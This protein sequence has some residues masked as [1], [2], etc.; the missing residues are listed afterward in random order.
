MTSAMKTEQCWPSATPSGA[1]S[2]SAPSWA[3]DSTP[4]KRVPLLLDEGAGAGGAGLVHGGVDD[5]PAVEPDVL[6]VLPA[7]LEDGVDARVDVARAGGVG[8]DL[9][10][11]RGPPRRR[12]RWPAASR[13]SRAPSRWRRSRAR[14]G[15]PAVAAQE[16]LHQRLG[17]ADRVAVGPQVAV[18]ERLARG[19]G[20]ASTALEPVEPM[21]K[22]RTASRGPAGVLRGRL[23]GGGAPG[24]ARA[25]SG[26]SRSSGGLGGRLEEGAERRPAGAARRRPRARRRARRGGGRRRRS[27]PARVMPWRLAKRSKW[28]RI[29]AERAPRRRPAPAGAGPGAA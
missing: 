15:R 10:D 18:P 2:A 16:P 13:R 28:S 22:P 24:P 11:A 29:R 14:G 7:D 6:G 21:S 26:G 19:R 25:A 17:R 27:R 9:V 4:S 20:R 5:A 3:T 12:S 1:A 23:A 8:G